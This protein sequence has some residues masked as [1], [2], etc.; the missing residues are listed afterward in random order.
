MSL[1]L[2][3]LTVEAEKQSNALEDVYWYITNYCAISEIPEELYGVWTNMA[4]DFLRY[5]LLLENDLDP[6][7]EAVEGDITGL[8]EGDTSISFGV[9]QNGAVETA[10]LDSHKADLDTVVLNYTAQLNAFRRFRW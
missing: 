9:I 5:Q 6:E 1:S 7:K 2:L 3:P 4:V 10:I 8:S